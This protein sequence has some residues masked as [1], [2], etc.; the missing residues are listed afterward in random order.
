MGGDSGT[1]KHKISHFMSTLLPHEVGYTTTT[2]V[3]LKEYSIK[4]TVVYQLEIAFASRALASYRVKT[5]CSDGSSLNSEKSSFMHLVCLTALKTVLSQLIFRSTSRITQ[6]G[7][8]ETQTTGR[9]EHE[10]CQRI[11]LDP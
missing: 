6:R 2:P 11:C 5:H 7:G 10:A 4:L 8:K 1:L 9:N 3:Q